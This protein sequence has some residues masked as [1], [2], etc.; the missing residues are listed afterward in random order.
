MT[1]RDWI[2]LLISFLYPIVLLL[3]AELIRRR[4]VGVWRA[5]PV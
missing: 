4:A 1:A 3:A 2:A 5:G